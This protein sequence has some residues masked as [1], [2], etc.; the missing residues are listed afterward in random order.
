MEDQI[1]LMVKAAQEACVENLR[2]NL[3]QGFFTPKE[4]EKI[5]SQNFDTLVISKSIDYLQQTGHDWLSKFLC[6]S[7]QS[8]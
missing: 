8:V 3:E 2:L 6:T 7:N 5:Y 4:T 1:N